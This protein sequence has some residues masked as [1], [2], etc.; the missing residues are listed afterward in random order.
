MMS[1]AAVATTEDLFLGGRLVIEQPA[2]GFRAG[3]DAVLLAA[4]V[5]YGNDSALR[6]LD[7][8]AGV[9][10]AG[11]CVA[12]RLPSADVSLVEVAPPLARLA[13]ANV[14]RNGLTARVSVVEADIAEHASVLEAHG[15]LPAAF[16]VVIANPPYLTEGRHR[17]PEDATAA[18]A[19][20]MA[21]G[22]LEPWLRFM[23]RM[24]RGGGGMALIHRAD[25][26]GAVIAATGERFGDLRILPVHPRAGE[27]AHRI[28][29][30][31][32]KGSRAPLVLLPALVLHGPGNDFLPEV[33]AILRDGAPLAAVG[34]RY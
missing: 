25:A 24:C 29:V 13:R 33:K 32:R 28:V 27:P 1:N 18:A 31:G 5:G 9:G 8:G 12:T 6:V 30:L 26:L 4:A 15:L 19:F 21:E 22:G 14:Q 20:G 3:L 23:A 16:D 2:R 10:T 34:A 17:L 7:V 11:L